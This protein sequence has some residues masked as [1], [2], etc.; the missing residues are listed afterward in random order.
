MDRVLVLA[1][2][3]DDGECGCG[4]TISKFIEDGLDV[5]YVAFSAA[6]ESIPEGLPKDIT[7][8]EFK[9]ATAILGVK[10]DNLILYNYK[11]RKF[12]ETR[13]DILE[14]MVLLNKNINPDL[15]IMPSPHDTHQDHKVISE[16]GFRAFKRSSVIGYEIPWNNLTFNTNLFIFLTKAYINKKLKAL[17]CYNSQKMRMYGG[18]KFFENLAKVRGVQIGADYAEC[19]ETIR[20]VIN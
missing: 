17:D 19:F 11:V 1:P 7:K 20:W 14:D 4:G 6:K 18:S 3:T 9:K 8:K 5:Y 16:E 2:H 13:Q 15:V 12:P 10:P